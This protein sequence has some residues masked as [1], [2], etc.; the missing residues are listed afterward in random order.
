MRVSDLK[1]VR[2]ENGE[3]FEAD[4]TVDRGEASELLNSF[5]K[6]ESSRDIL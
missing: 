2:R 3:P 6:S 5:L 4:K 1:S